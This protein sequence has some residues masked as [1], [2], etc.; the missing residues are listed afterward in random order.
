MHR[1]YNIRSPA[2]IAIYDNRIEFFSPG[3]FP[4]PLD[5]HNLLEG[6]SFLRNPAICRIFR[7]AHLIEKLGTGLIALFNSYMQMDLPRP[8]VLERTS[9]VKCVLPRSTPENSHLQQKNTLSDDLKSVYDLFGIADE[10]TVSH[11]MKNL[12]LPR[13]T[14]GRRLDTLVKSKLI[15]K[16]GQGRTAHYVQNIAKE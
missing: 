15:I 9:F 2:K 12:N 6:M 1:N 10:V 5:T 4:G 3:D 8:H 14:A 11:V 13:A 7:E 16:R